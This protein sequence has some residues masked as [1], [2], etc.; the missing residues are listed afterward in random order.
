VAFPILNLFYKSGEN[1]IAGTRTS[2]PNSVMNG[3]TGLS[4]YSAYTYPLLPSNY[5]A[6]AIST[7]YPVNNSSLVVPYI[8]GN[9][10]FSPYGEDY[11]KMSYLAQGV[12]Y[13]WRAIGINGTVYNET[14]GTFT[15][16]TTPGIGFPVSGNYQ[17][18]CTISVGKYTTP[19]TAVKNIIAQ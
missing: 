17:L 16:E 3:S 15:T 1:L 13:H 14:I 7:L 5:D 6:I 9:K 19:I 12:S 4:D 8:S 10:Y 11:F 18:Q 2:D